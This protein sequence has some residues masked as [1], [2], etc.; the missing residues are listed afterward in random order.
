MTVIVDASDGITLIG[1]APDGDR[2]L[3]AALTIAPVLVAAD[4]G[5]DHCLASGRTPVAVIG[6]MDS[7][8]DAAA[9][10]YGDRL[11][12]VDEQET[13][14]FDKALRH[15][16]APVVIAAGFAGGR[17]DHELAVINT[18]LRRP[19]LPCI[20]LG[21]ESLTFL[22]PPHIQLDLPPG[23][24]LSLFPMAAAPLRSTG[25]VWPTDG[26]DFRPEGRIGTSN[27]V[28]DAGAVTLAAEAPAMLV[29]LPRAAL[30]AA[31]AAVRPAARW[32]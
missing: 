29:I 30:G 22:C 1:G 24:P 14:D 16:A 6:D 17:F 8:S 7:I 19:D 26:L 31:A 20:V 4:G 5:A 23:M 27:A 3:A 28:G 21:R 15:V 25:L 9:A 2:D 11:H 32:G 12:K 13:T 10:A 18:L